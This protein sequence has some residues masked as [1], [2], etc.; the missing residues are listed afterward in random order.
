MGLG[1]LLLASVGT[2]N[3]IVNMNPVITFFKKVYKNT[4]N[5]SNEVLPQYFKSMPNFGKRLTVNISNNADML[6]EIA[7]YF[8]LPDIP[9]SNHSSL[10]DG[11]KKFA[12][13]NNIAFTMIKYIDIEIGGILISRHYGDWLNIHNKLNIGTESYVGFDTTNLTV[14]TNGKSSYKLY[15]PLSFFFNLSPSL[16]LPLVAL[17]KQ[18]IKLH[19]ELNDFSMCYNESPTHYFTI[20]SYI[21]LFQKDEIIRQSVDNNKSAGV[22]VYFDINTKRV[23]YNLLYN[24]FLVPTITNQTLLTKYYIIGDVSGFI[25]TPSYNSIVV[26][27]ENYFNSTIPALKDSYLLANYIYLDTDERWFFMNNKLEYTVP[28]V[29][30]VL[31]KD[32]T[33][34][35]SNYKLQLNNPHQILIW[36]V[37]LNSNKNINDYFNYS[38][39]PI[40]LT[41]E[42]LILSNTLVINSIKRCELSNYQYYTYLQNYINKYISNNNIYQYSF[43]LEPTGT[44]PAG[45][46]NFSIVD[47]SYIQLNLNKIVN[48]QNTINI[49]AYGIYFNIFVVNNGN[50]SMKYYI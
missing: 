25:T 26:K 3:T 16:A 17:T 2:E 28:I 35:N 9:Q 37:L 4:S 15:V 40:T 27:D 6:Q 47:D 41:E 12:W 29:L 49:K 14:Y 33:S 34:I 36:R 31:D 46:L 5:I 1:L 11:I 42:P 39:Y 7:I 30:N 18:E 20:D 44:K 43:G 50:S 38:S 19:L 48:Y 32:I 10:P 23:Y 22:F 45:T 8:E 21:C 24:E 13:A